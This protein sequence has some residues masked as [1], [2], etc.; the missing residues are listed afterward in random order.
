MSAAK[1]VLDRHQELRTLRQPEEKAWRDIAEFLR[2]DD[3]SFEPSAPTTQRDDAEIFDSTALYANDDFAGGVFSQMSNPANR[4]FEIADPDPELNAFGPVK[5]WTWAAANVVYASLHPN[6]SSF[7]VNAPATFADMGAFGFGVFSQQE[8]VGRQ[9]I[10]D[11]SVPIGQTYL[12]V[13][14]AGETSTCHNAFQMRGRQAKLFFARLGSPLDDARVRDDGTYNFVQAV[15]PNPEAR[16][17]RV[18]PRYKPFRSVYVSQDVRDLYIDGGYDTLPYHVVGWSARGGRIYPRGP[19]HNARAD[20][21]TLNEIERSDLIATQFAAEPLLLLRDED[22]VSA[23]DIVPNAV[24]FGAVSQRG[25]AYAQYLERQSQLNP[26]LQ[27]AN[28]K[29]QAIQ[30]AFRFSL[31]QL[32]N[33]PQMTRG[34]FEGWQ[35]EQLRQMAPNLIQVQKGLGSFL[36]RRYMI[37]DGMGLIPPAPPELAERALNIQFVSPLDKVQR[38]DEGKAVLTLHE[39]IERMAVTDPAIRDNFNGD[40]AAR[41]LAASLYTVPGI[42]NDERRVAAIRDQRAKAQA[43]AGQLQQ[44]GQVA[45]IAAVAAHAAQAATAAGARTG[46]R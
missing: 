30:M 9:R 32:L 15:S 37:L 6:V 5:A 7:Y 43:A 46:G 36:A 39:G 33:R 20:M 27:K 19:G 28:Q 25:E 4:W 38:L 24:L 17:D 40:V 35:A 31:M 12:D 22:V 26:V 3:T 29:R 13:D 1:E 8:M 44:A 41:T 18:G 23:A 2:P 10:A 14:E 45:D 42:L 11:R 21:R 16:A 34:E